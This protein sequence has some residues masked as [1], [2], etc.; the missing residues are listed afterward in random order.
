MSVL[1]LKLRVFR[2]F[3]VATAFA[4]DGSPALA[5]L[6]TLNNRILAWLT[7]GPLRHS[8]SRTP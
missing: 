8:F 4:S 3:L 5:Q 2:P 6:E 7:A 1:L